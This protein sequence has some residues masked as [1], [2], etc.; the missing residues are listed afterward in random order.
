[1]SLEAPRLDDRTFEDL[2]DEVRARIPLYTPE[3]TDHNLSD[4]G[5]TLLELFA[6]MTDVIL[7]RL[8]RVPEKHYIKFMELIGMRLQEAVPARA[9]ITFWLS[10]PQPNPFVIPVDSEVATTRTETED[11]IVFT[12]DRDMTIKVPELNYLM[13]SYIEEETEERR[14]AGQ[15]VSGVLAGYDNI[16]VFA[17]DPPRTDDALYFGFDEDLSNHILGIEFE[18]DQAEGSGIDPRRPP[19][20][21]EVLSLQEETRWERIDVDFDDTLGL[22]K[23]GLIR[24]HVPELRR[25]TRNEISAYWVRLRLD[26]TD[27][28]SRY[29]VSPRLYRLTVESW[30][31][32]VNATNATRVYNEVLGR[33]DGTPG[34]IFY[35]E[36]QPIV[37]RAAGEYILV[38]LEDGREQRW[39]EVSDFSLSNAVDHHYTI[40]SNTGEVRFGPALP[41]P[42]GEIK[43]YG[44]LPPK[45]A[46][47]VMRSYRYGGGQSGNVAPRTIN[48]L[49]TSLPYVDT[50]MNRKSA[51]GGLDAENME[52]AKL[53][54]PGY[55]R[56]LQRA[57][58]AGDFE[59]LTQVAAPGEVGRVYCLQPPNTNRGENKLLVIPAVP[60]LQGYI[61][62]ESLELTTELRER[63]HN[64]LDERRLLATQLEVTMPIYQWVQTEVYLRASQHFDAE[65]V[66]QRVERRLLEF[67][68]PLTGGVNGDGWPFGRD[69]M[70]SDIMAAI[71]GVEGVQYIRSV[72]LF[73]I[74]Y[75]NRQFRVGDEADVIALPADGLVAS[76]Q[77]RVMPD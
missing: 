7:Y 37:A 18:V 51:A 67:V 38:R 36:H 24:V 63:I 15:N 22:N 61:S 59:Y 44:S 50:V 69:L 74:T 77:H 28:D 1:M 8:N 43:R 6:F 68:N 10:A 72:R 9:E 53:R 52:N 32:T 31:G 58:T 60:V 27:T 19:Y 55:L 46:M 73:P 35:L 30:G 20:F 4:P 25:A 21:W 2:M 3:W 45:G 23:S 33:S 16:P 54:V 65:V 64:Y 62:P 71:S 39:Q 17:S 66:R 47:I 48:V 70:V 56:S 42:N 34:Q 26:F 76:Y 40:E 14:Y 11:A 5:I 41:Q 13:S 75:E 57:V 29:S 12:T 49:R